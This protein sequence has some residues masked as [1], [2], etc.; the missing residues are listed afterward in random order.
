MEQHAEQRIGKYQVREEIGRGT[1][2]IVYRGYDPDMDRTVAIK[3]LTP[4]FAA[5]AEFVQLFLSRAR[6][7]AQLKHPYLMGVYDAGQQNGYTWMGM[8]YLSGISLRVLIQL[9]G[10][11]LTGEVQTIVRQLAGAVDY[12]HRA[13]LFHGD[14]RPGN[15]IVC[16]PGRPI[17]TE[18]GVVRHSW[19]G[20]V[21]NGT[22]SAAIAPEQVAGDELGAWTD[23]YALGAVAYE[24]L[25][26]R[27]PH[28]ADSASALLY[29]AAH[30][31]VPPLTALRP[32]LPPAVTPVL[33]KALAKEPR[34]RY[35]TGADFAAALE[36]ALKTAPAAT[37]E[38]A[39]PPA[40]APETQEASPTGDAVPVAGAAAAPPA[41]AAPA[42][43]AVLPTV[44]PPEPHMPPPWESVPIRA[45][46]PSPPQS[47]AAQPA[48]ITRLPAEAPAAAQPAAQGPRM[49][50]VMASA[51]TPSERLAQRR[52]AV[53]AAA[54]PGHTDASKE[55]RPSAWPWVLLGVEALLLLAGIALLVLLVTGVL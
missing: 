48:K 39:A 7:M 50:R 43:A 24:M 41:A 18:L 34:T 51:P 8:E 32:D 9:Q 45:T 37:A 15:V 27:P 35:Y 25:A 4:Q 23:I 36:T 22:V 38:A 53:Q 5:D 40:A 42:E 1:V 13:G 49:P 29:Q 33:E 44:R 16:P 14:V 47:A 52:A 28:T 2:S 21:A 26:G 19:E 30:E 17:L 55:R 46:P 3:V 20:Q 31:A 54:A 11:M 6:A 10:L 12:V